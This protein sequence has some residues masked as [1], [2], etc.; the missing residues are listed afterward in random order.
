VVTAEDARAIWAKGVAAAFGPTAATEKIV[1]TVERL[2]RA[3]VD[4]AAG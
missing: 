3:G 2:A 4:R 1:T